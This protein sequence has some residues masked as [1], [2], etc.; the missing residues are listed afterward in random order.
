MLRQKRN[1]FFKIIC[2][3]LVGT[4]LFVESPLLCKA[5]ENSSEKEVAAV[6]FT[7]EE[8]EYIANAGT[9]TVGQIHNRY[10]ITSVNDQTGELSGINEDI[11]ALIAK[12]SGLKLESQAIPVDEKPMVGL[13]KGEFDVAMGVVRMQSFVDDKTLQISDTFLES[14][15][16]AVMKKGENF[17]PDKKYTI[18]LKNSFQAMQE[19]ITATYPDY[20]LKFFSTDEE[21]LSAL[22]QGDVDLMMQNI[23]VTNYLLQKPQYSDVQIL[24]TTFLTE[25]SCFAA[26]SEMDPRFMSIINKC[27]ASIT[28]EQLNG[29][30]LANTTAKPYQLTIGDVLYKYRAELITFIALIA[31]CIALLV[32]M[33]ISRQRHFKTMQ[34]K[35]EQLAQAVQQAQSANVAKSRFLAQMSH[36]IRTPMNAIIGLSALSRGYLDN[37]EKMIDTLN[38][39]DGSSKLLLGII[40]DVLDMSAIESGKLKIDSAQYDFKKAISTLTSL[41]YQQASQKNIDF[42]VH[43]KG[44]TEEQ[45]IGDEL[46]V[47]QILMNLLSNAI[48][49]TPANGK[50]DFYI[51]QA[52]MS[53]NKIHIRFIVKDSGC[54]MSEEMMGRLFQPFEQ[55]SAG[56]ARKHG[57]SGLGLS[58]AKQLTEKMG[59]SIQ[60]ESKQDEGSTFTVDI[61]FGTCEQMI[62][63]SESSFASIRVLVVDDDKDACAYCGELLDR[64]GVKHDCAYSGEEALNMLGEAE[65]QGNTY[66]MCM[67]DWKMPDMNGLELTK[68]IRSIFGQEEIIIIV[69]AYDLNEVEDVGI[70]A[71][72]NYFMPKPLF[73]STIYNALMRILNGEGAAYSKGE[74]SDYDFKGKKVLIAEDVALNLEVAVS[75]LKMVGLETVCAEDGKQ[76]VEAFESC[77]AGTFDCILMD[78]NM[79][80]MDGYEAARRIRASKK[81]DAKTIPIYAMTANA[82]SSDVT[83]ALNAGMNGHIAKPIETDVLYKTLETAFRE[84]ELQ[85]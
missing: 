63:V 84:K 72:A 5:V 4:V 26:L 9:I 33:L 50:I 67:V 73:Q 82:F 60:V 28:Q 66:Q 71:G 22:L 7:D 30:I 49:F 15:V 58:I 46:R 53:Q 34:V 59:G 37:R 57:G 8:K 40:N 64:M 42:N 52:S 17:D 43:L 32:M 56:T 51:I 62:E 36:E 1:T 24:P 3:I 13:K 76:A 12:M 70:E 45:V 65:D 85:Q 54:G 55:E 74:S 29:I 77:P 21:G 41:F 6:T 18:A 39:I 47:N 61:P 31:I 27:I 75:L 38:K 78:I 83:E 20:E 19:Y 2:S 69:S 68:N 16:A 10:P 35:S 80:V 48:K 23:Y 44:V 14:T 25:K 81:P 79:P 11:L